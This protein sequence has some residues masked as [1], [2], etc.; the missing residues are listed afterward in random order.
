[1]PFYAVIYALLRYKTWPFTLQYIPLFPY[2]IHLLHQIYLQEP[3]NKCRNIGP[4]HCHSLVHAMS[5]PFF[6]SQNE[7]RVSFFFAALYNFSGKYPSFV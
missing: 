1:M 7:V 5:L 3:P 4:S 6:S 2:D